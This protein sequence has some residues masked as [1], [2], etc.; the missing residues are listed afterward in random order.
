[1]KSQ[2]LDAALNSAIGNPNQSHSIASVPRKPWQIAIPILAIFL[3][4]ASAVQAQ[5][6]NLHIG[7]VYP[8]GGQRGSTFEA[9]V[10][11]QFLTSVSSVDVSGGGVQAAI[12]ELIKPIS[13]KELN[14][15]RIQ[16]DQLLARKAVVSKDFTALEKFRSFKNAKTV[17]TDEAAHD[18]ELEELKTKYANATWT[19]EDENLLKEVRKKMSM[20]V[21]RPANP[22]ISELAVVRFTVAPDAKPGPRELRIATPQALS[23][24]LAFHIGQLPE[25]SKEASKSITEQKSA[26]AKT[27]VAPKGGKSQPEMNVALPAVVNGQILAGAVDRFRFTARKGQRLVIAASARDLIPYIPDAVPGWFQATLALYDAE[28]KEVA[29]DDDYTF[30]PD[31][32]IYYEV[33]ADGE[34]VVEIKDA[35]YRGREDFVYRITLGELP[36]VTSIFPLGGPAGS[37]TTVELAGWN[38]PSASLPVDGK[39]KGRGIRQ[40]TVTKDGHVSNAV[41]FAIDTL[42]ECLERESLAKAEKA[43]PVTLPMIVNG[44]IDRPDD[45]DV[46]SFE[47]KAGQEIVAEVNARRLNSPLDS[48]LTLTDAAGRQLAENDDHEDKA[49]GL[50]THHADSYLRFTL[51]ANGT[52]QLRLGDMQHKGG[53]E[54]AYRLRIGPPQPD[55]DLRIVPSTINARLAATSVPLTVYALRRDGF[56]GEIALA[57]KDAPEGFTLSGARVPEGQD[58]VRLTLNLAGLSSTQPVSLRLEGRATVNGRQ[59]SRPVVPAEDMMQAFEYRHLVPARELLLA[60]T[61]GAKSKA[62]SMKILGASPVRIPA[63]GTAK[64]EVG[65]VSSKSLSKLHVELSEP[66][67]GITIKRVSPSSEGMEIVLQCDAGKAK[68]GLQGNLIVAFSAEKAGAS[69]KAKAASQRRAPLATLPAIP[70]EVVKPEK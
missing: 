47:G 39:K 5:Q 6:P 61:A 1:M 32:V 29:Y 30:H 62:T 52:Y 19:A 9:V 37:Q 18:K 43:Q 60:V 25:Y 59:V 44:R 31:P 4:A 8:A 53:P 21:R 51:P 28:G 17:K 41:P 15:L 36:F 26:I 11:G 10:A 24:P 54:Y 2:P 3:V 40:L 27:A 68:S 64:V 55:F 13:G 12:V 48:V 42:P 45:T 67:E 33:P 57:L 38:L 56:S 22:A 16:V 7:Y 20:A 58:R 65:G 49:A 63:G 70:F 66:P 35:I 23:N 34:Y 69:T 14:D 50:T 46:F